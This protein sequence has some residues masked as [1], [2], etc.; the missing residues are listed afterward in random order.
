MSIKNILKTTLYTGLAA[1][2]VTTCGGP[3][4]TKF[5]TLITEGTPVIIEKPCEGTP[6]WY[7]KDGATEK[8]I[9]GYGVGLSQ[10]VGTAERKA[11]DFATADIAREYEVYVEEVTNQ[12][13]EETGINRNNLII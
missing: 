2:V 8:A 12:L 5:G 7:G 4:R 11:R 6:E 3:Q 9:F 10:D 13:E 1:A